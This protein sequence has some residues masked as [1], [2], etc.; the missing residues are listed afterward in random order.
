MT[1]SQSPTRS[2]GAVVNTAVRAPAREDVLTVLDTVEGPGL[3]PNQE[4][5][6]QHDW[7]Y[8]YQFWKTA[9]EKIANAKA[10]LDK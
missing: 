2:V 6:A 4:Y 7:P 10:R 9:M 5:D 3:Q 8:S 1:T